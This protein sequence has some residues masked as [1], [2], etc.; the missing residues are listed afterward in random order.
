MSVDSGE[1]LAM[2]APRDV[3]ALSELLAVYEFAPELY[4]VYSEEGREYTV[5]AETRACTCPDAQYN[6]P[7]GGCKHARRMA[8]WR[9][10]EQIPG[11]VNLEAFDPLLIEHLGLVCVR[12][13]SGHG[14]SFQHFGNGEATADD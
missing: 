7:E 9:S 5:D 6:N 2:T 3:R 8:L 12:T 13:N 14:S 11:W 1:S 10:D 4:W